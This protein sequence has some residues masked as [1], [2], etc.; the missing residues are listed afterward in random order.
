[1]AS[2][3]PIKKNETIFTVDHSSKPVED[4]YVVLFSMFDLPFAKSDKIDIAFRPVS[5]CSFI[6]RDKLEHTNYLGNPTV[7]NG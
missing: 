3:A 4:F 6:S 7:H 5:M 1:M 2:K